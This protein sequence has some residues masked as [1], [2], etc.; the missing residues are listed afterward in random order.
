MPNVRVMA[1]AV[2]A[3]F[4]F[5]AVLS[6]AP[7]V[8]E[9]AHFLYKSPEEV[10][11]VLSGPGAPLLVDVRS[12]AEFDG[13]RIP[14]S[15]NV[16]LFSLKTKNFPGPVVVIQKAAALP[17]TE[18]EIRRLQAARPSLFLLE[19][20]IQGWKAQKLPLE[21]DPAAI[22]DLDRPAP[23]PLKL[24]AG[25]AQTLRTGTGRPGERPCPTCP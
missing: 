11:A 8:E 17:E 20:G 9:A 14:G 21:G 4:L 24:P 15:L 22:R 18:R 5:S 3:S 25:P 13:C 12:A 19:G 7:R 1:L 2:T 23:A 16:P 10:R 6:S